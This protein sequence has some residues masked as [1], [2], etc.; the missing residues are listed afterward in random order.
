MLILANTFDCTRGYNEVEFVMKWISLKRNFE[1][2]R[3]LSKMFIWDPQ[4]WMY[5]CYY[6]EN[7]LVANLLWTRRRKLFLIGKLIWPK[8]PIAN[9]FQH[10]EVLKLKHDFY[11]NDN[12][13]WLQKKIKSSRLKPREYFGILG[14]IG[15]LWDKFRIDSIRNE[16]HFNY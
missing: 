14:C 9:C 1:I 10:V 8:Y 12:L 7:L 2:N 13:Q 6:F 15:L 5:N 4:W 11:L 3:D 16:Q